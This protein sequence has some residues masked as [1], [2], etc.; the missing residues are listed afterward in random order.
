MLM[1]S[2]LI[3]IHAPRTGSDVDLVTLDAEVQCISIHAPRTGSDHSCFAFNVASSNF[4][5]R[6]PHGERRP[7]L[8]LIFG[9]VKFQSTLPA[10]GATPKKSSKRRN[11][12]FQSTLP[13]R[14]AT[15]DGTAHRG[16]GRISIHAP[17]TGSDDGTDKRLMDELEISI[18]AP[19][20]GSDVVHV[21]DFP[22]D[23]GISIHA[24]RTGSDGHSA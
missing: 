21:V 15:T 10:R 3:S 6:S 13:A 7:A 23:I 8:V 17:R 22:L 24:P 18:H 19:R 16:K 1:V 14:G 9:C 11:S 4:N 2:F 12:L 5:P 20:T